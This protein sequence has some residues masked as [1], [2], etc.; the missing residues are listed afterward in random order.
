MMTGCLQ[1]YV[2]ENQQVWLAGSRPLSDQCSRYPSK[3][4][5]LLGVTSPVIAPRIGAA[6]DAEERMREWSEGMDPRFISW[7][8]AAIQPLTSVSLMHGGER[9]SRH[10]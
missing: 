7:K 10:I 2:K 9:R 6:R 4:R 3:K 5:M 8:I 1:E